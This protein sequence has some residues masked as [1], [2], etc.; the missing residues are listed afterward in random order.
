MT[1]FINNAAMYRFYTYKSWVSWLQISAVK[2]QV[3][4][5][6]MFD[7]DMKILLLDFLYKKYLTIQM[8]NKY[9]LVLPRYVIIKSTLQNSYIKD[10]FNLK[11]TLFWLVL[12]WQNLL[13]SG[14]ERDKTMTDKLM[15]I[16]NYVK[17]N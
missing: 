10:L 13:R 17:Q 5:G 3:S 15:Y 14:I 2:Y 4:K 16:S 7:I 12:L 1:I 8:Y 11:T 9:L 6:I